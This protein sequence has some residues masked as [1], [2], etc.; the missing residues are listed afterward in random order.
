M[1]I[2]NK[3]QSLLTHFNLFFQVKHFDRRR[4]YL[5]FRAKIDAGYNPLGQDNFKTSGFKPPS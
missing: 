2:T 3:F 4:E 5:K 1:Y